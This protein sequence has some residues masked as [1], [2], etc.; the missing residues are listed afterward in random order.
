MLAHQRFASQLHIRNRLFMKL[1]D[2][3]FNVRSKG[4][5]RRDKVPPC[6]GANLMKEWRD[7]IVEYHNSLRSEVARGEF[8]KAGGEEFPKAINMYE[9]QYSCSLEVDANDEAKKCLTNPSS[10]EFK[11]SRRNVYK[12]R[13]TY[14]S[15]ERFAMLVFRRR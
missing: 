4:T 12:L 1:C 10:S 13:T 5:L 7:Y 14:V 6:V 9:M 2:M 11:T 15:S 8:R 3:I